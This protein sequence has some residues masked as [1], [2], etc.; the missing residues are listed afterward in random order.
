MKKESKLF[1]SY[2]EVVLGTNVDIDETG[3]EAVT[4]YHD[5]LD[6]PEQ[7]PK[8]ILSNLPDPLLLLITSYEDNKGDEWIFYLATENNDASKWL[9]A[10][11]LKNDAVFETDIPI[12]EGE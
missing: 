3:W 2:L 6:E 7:F 10:L 4:F 9:Y 11:C 5:E 1:Q 12:E 8:E